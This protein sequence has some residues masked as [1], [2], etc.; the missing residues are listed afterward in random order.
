[1][2]SFVARTFKVYSIRGRT[3]F[4]VEKA[5]ALE[6]FPASLILDSRVGIRQS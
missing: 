5:V 6:R 2:E 4:G 3:E 1:M